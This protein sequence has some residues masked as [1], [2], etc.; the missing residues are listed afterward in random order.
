M[1][2]ANGSRECAPNDKLC[3]THRLHLVGT[4]GFARL[5][6]SCALRVP[7]FRCTG[8]TGERDHDEGSEGRE[9]AIRGRASSLSRCAAGLSHR[10]APDKPYPEGALALSQQCP[11]H[12]LCPGRNNPPLSPAAEGRGASVAGPD[13]LCPPKAPTRSE[14]P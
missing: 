10:R 5:N 14:E 12:F 4:M 3:D 11:R 8:S 13:L 7:N 9:S 2:G 1:G 6:P